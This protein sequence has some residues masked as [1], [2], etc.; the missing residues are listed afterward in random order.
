M[1]FQF[2]QTLPPENSELK[3]QQKYLVQTQN[4]K[5]FHPMGD[6]FLDSY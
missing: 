4:L 3:L 6:L 5:C 2:I 1:P